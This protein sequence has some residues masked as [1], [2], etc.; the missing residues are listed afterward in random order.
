MIQFDWTRQEEQ[1]VFDNDV[2]NKLVKRVTASPITEYSVDAGNATNIVW[3]LLK[4]KALAFILCG[5]GYTTSLDPLYQI[6][7]NNLV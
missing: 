1:T 4:N 7:G 2:E 3:T 6:A 5:C